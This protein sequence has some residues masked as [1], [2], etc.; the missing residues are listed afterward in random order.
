M[1]HEPR[2]LRTPHATP[3]SMDPASPWLKALSPLDDAVFSTPTLVVIQPGCTC[4][5]D[6][7]TSDIRPWKVS[8]MAGNLKLVPGKS[9]V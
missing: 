8:A 1:L 4:R 3:E 7:R 6:V 9:W 5:Q 2:V